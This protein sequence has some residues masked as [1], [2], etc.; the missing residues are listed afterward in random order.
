MSYD[1]TQSP[2]D[3]SLRHIDVPCGRCNG[4]GRI[5]GGHD[6][7]PSDYGTCPVCRGSGEVDVE[8]EP[9]TEEEIMDDDGR[10]AQP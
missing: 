7:D 4:H 9:V 1:P 2:C 5:Y 10:E 6:S 8:L 3:D